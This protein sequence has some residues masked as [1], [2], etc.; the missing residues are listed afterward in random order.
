[1]IED[2]WPALGHLLVE[3]LR[4]ARIPALI[5]TK[6]ES[7]AELAGRIAGDLAVSIAHL[8]RQTAALPV[9]PAEAQIDAALGTAIVLHG[10]DLI[11]WPALGVDLLTYLS[12]RA[13][14]TPTIAVWPGTVDD[15]RATASHPGRPDH[16]D[17]RLSGVIVL[18]GLRPSPFPDDP[19]FT[20]E[21]IAP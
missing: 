16:L 7:A 13:R 4:A 12:R 10:L 17:R 20:I 21:R 2:R 9:P 18:H 15:G 6:H 11:L 3:E 8:G 1:M 19:P 14:R 5:D